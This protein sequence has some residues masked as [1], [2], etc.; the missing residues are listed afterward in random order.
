MSAIAVIAIIVGAAI[1]LFLLVSVARRAKDRREQG[2]LQ[3]E[4]KRDDV[5]H[6]RDEAQ[7]SRVEAAVA[8][9]RAK[10]QATEAELH[11]ERAASRE[12]EVEENR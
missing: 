10:R 3:R 6:H 8:D 1:L 11:E 7:Q 5:E 2:Q 4:A 9:E 12:R